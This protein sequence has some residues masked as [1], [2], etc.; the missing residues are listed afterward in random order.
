MKSALLKM[1]GD[2]VRS[3]EFPHFLW[4]STFDF[5]KSLLSVAGLC[6]NALAPQEMCKNFPWK[7]LVLWQLFLTVTATL[8][9]W[10]TCEKKE[11][12]FDSLQLISFI[13]TLTETLK[14]YRLVSDEAWPSF[15]SP[16]TSACPAVRIDWTTA[17]AVSRVTSRDWQGH[18]V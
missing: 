11:C 14:V 6:I 9:L 13:T 15:I 12:L 18:F 3:L 1:T 7:T 16:P 5:F 17:V 8:I 4:L 2:F 10:A